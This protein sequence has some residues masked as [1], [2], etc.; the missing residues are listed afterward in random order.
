MTIPRISGIDALRLWVTIAIVVVV[1][2][3]KVRYVG[4][5]RCLGGSLCDLLIELFGLSSTDSIGND[6]EE[7]NEGN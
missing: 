7:K 5:S 1:Q 2:I 6:S 3:V 4:G